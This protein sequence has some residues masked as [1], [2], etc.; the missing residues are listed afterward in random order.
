MKNNI[1]VFKAINFLSNYLGKEP[2][3][4]IGRL[5]LLDDNIFKKI[6]ED[7]N[8]CIKFYELPFEE[9]AKSMGYEVVKNG[10]NFEIST[11]L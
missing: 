4:I 7:Y 3:D 10:K 8:S 11:V 5:A 1:E 6:K 2:V 9:R